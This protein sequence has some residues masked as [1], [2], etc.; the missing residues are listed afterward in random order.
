MEVRRLVVVEMTTLRNSRASHLVKR[1][2]RK[3]HPAV[4]DPSTHDVS[5]SD[6]YCLHEKASESRHT[7]A[8]ERPVAAD[9][10]KSHI[11]GS[12]SQSVGTRPESRLELRVSCQTYRDGC[13]L[14]SETRSQPTSVIV[15]LRNAVLGQPGIVAL[16]RTTG[17]PLTGRNNPL[18]AIPAARH[19]CNVDESARL[20]SLAKSEK[21]NASTIL[22]I[23]SKGQ[24]R[25]LSSN[26]RQ[27]GQRTQATKT[28]ELNGNIDFFGR[29]R[30]RRRPDVNRNRWLSVTVEAQ[31][32][33]FRTAP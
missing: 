25:S 17:Q 19:L 10:R 23:G 7:S 24:S 20:N 9:V 16:G 27:T 26:N 6:G 21:P 8:R 13:R 15:K 3:N 1:S 18:E 2:C 31:F 29:S 33:A 30:A 5:T 4:F 14:P 28:D 22:Y 11:R 32:R 12:S